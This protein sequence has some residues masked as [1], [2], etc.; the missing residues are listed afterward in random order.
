[1]ANVKHFSDFVIKWESDKYA[2]NVGDK[3]G[4]TKYGITLDTWKHVGYDKNGDKKIDAND[5]KLL[6]KN[7]FMLVLKKNFWDKWKADNIKNQSIAEIVVDWLW[8][9][10]K[11][12][13]IYPQR[14]LGVKDD[15]IVGN[16]TIAALNNYP[17]QEKL[18][19]LIKAARLQF[20]DNIVKRNPSQKKWINGWKNRINDFKFQK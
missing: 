5:V 10:G 14:I 15:G 13:I 16:K 19:N 9:S 17:N 18:F 2:N 4:P 7:D 11:W 12:G 3:G 20:V 1:M 6:D 8:A